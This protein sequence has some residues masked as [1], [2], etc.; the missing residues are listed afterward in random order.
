MQDLHS[1][2]YVLEEVFEAK[3]AE[4][5]EHLAR[6]GSAYSLGSDCATAPL[7]S[8]SITDFGVGF[9]W[10]EHRRHLFLRD[11]TECKVTYC[12]APVSLRIVTND[13]KSL[14][15]VSFRLRIVTPKLL[16]VRA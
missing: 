10:R 8:S 11:V 14:L 6:L 15:L 2:E 13:G 4:V 9:A 5:F 16:H 3:S 12:H 1:N 7:R